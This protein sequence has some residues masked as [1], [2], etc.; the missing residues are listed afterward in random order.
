M[1]NV[2]SAI[3]YLL[4]RGLIDPDWIINGDLTIRCAARR[5][6]N[7]RIEGPSGAGFL[8][9]QADELAHGGHLTLS[10]EAAFHE[11]C[12]HEPAVAQVTELVA[13]IAFR[14]RERS[15]H[16]L[17]LVVGAVSLRSYHCA[18]DA[19][20]FPDGP[21]RALGQALGT[22]HRVFRL[23]AFAEHP[24]LAWLRDHLPGAL[25]QHR[26]SP[27]TL[28]TL[29][30]AGARMLRILQDHTDLGDQLDRLGSRW[31][32]DTVI[33]GDIKSDNILV[34]PVRQEPDDASVEV[35]IVDWEFVQIGDP[36][37]D[38]AGALHD[39]LIFWTS[40]M[41]L[42][43]TH[44]AEEM[45]D[46]A[47]YPLEVLRPAIRAFWEGYLSTAEVGL[48]QA[49]DLL[50]RAV[51]FSAA[52]LIQAAHELCVREEEILAQAVILMQISANLLAEPE[53]GQVHLYGVPLGT[54]P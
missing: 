28:A 52:R 20:G 8:I 36:A 11:F 43:P 39:Y 3:P 12:R 41:P 48:S 37:W 2:D 9:K 5:N 14:D 31:R 40:S 15:L 54:E 33:H 42:G 6:R 45:V 23:P 34:R 16:A 24:R 19:D 35:L 18:Q 32:P 47:R 30:P 21:S 46:Q 13:G 7:L 17:E 4:E 27:A 10:N 49:D 26:P 1:L 25:Q 44:S 50:R 22:V 38:L 53:S 29:S 51:L